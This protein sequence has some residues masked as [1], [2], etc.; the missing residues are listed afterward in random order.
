MKKAGL[1]FKEVV[2]AIS[3]IGLLIL[4]GLMAFAYGA[5]AI[6][7]LSLVTW[8]GVWA[9]IGIGIAGWLWWRER[10]RAEEAEAKVR[11][12]EIELEDLDKI[13]RRIKQYLKPEDFLLP[14]GFSFELPDDEDTKHH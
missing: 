11:R 10:K 9:A 12:L 1:I 2:E 14:S 4:L 5:S 6:G 7:M 8:P 3:T 13:E